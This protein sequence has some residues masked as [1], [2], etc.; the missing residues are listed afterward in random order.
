[1]V[2]GRKIFIGI[3]LKKKVL[4]TITRQHYGGLYTYIL[5]IHTTKQYITIK[6]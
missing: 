3:K 1:M 5:L 6:Y 2:F 4:C